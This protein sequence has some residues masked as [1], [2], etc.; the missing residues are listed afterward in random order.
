MVPV[1]AHNIFDDFF[2]NRFLD[3][4]EDDI[5]KPI[6]HKKWSRDLDRMMIDENDPN[7]TNGETVKTS[8]VYTNKNGVESKKSVTTKKKI[9]DGKANEE[10]V[11][12]YDFPNGEKNVTKTIKSADG[13]IDS[14]KWTLKKGEGMP[15]ELTN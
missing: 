11:E 9:V 3:M 10:T 4:E 2:G 14:H 1:R 8:S 15:K 7:M 13:K 5:F 12:E 6:F